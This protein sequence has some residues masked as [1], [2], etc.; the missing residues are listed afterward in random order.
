M[1]Y[2]LWQK[3]VL[4]LIK[5]SQTQTIVDCVRGFFGNLRVLRCS[6]GDICIMSLTEDLARTLTSPFATRPGRDRAAGFREGDRTQ[7]TWACHLKQESA[8]L[9]QKDIMLK[10]HA[11]D[12]SN[13]S[14]GMVASS[15]E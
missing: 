6:N 3:E 12:S 8:F 15:T 5:R 10:W 11:L 2:F 13:V 14:T 4:E 7:R 1:I 9:G